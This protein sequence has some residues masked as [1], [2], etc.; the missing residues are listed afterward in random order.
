MHAPRSFLSLLGLALG[1]A[2]VVTLAERLA[3]AL[4]SSR[5]TAARR[6][7]L[8]ERAAVL[9][10]ELEGVRIVRVPPEASSALELPTYPFGPPKEPA[11][12]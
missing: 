3:A 11:Q 5:S 4:A 12:A 8:L 10:A 7:E 1:A 6:V 9:E 2:L